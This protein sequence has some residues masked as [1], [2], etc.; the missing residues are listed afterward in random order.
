MN[1]LSGVGVKLMRLNG[2]QVHQWLLRWFNPAPT[3]LEPAEFYQ[4]C[5]MPNKAIHPR[6]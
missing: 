5:S 4:K 6:I 1:A 2:K 3:L